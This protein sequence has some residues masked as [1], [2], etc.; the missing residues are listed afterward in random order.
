MITRD[1]GYYRRVAL[2]QTFRRVV[3]NRFKRAPVMFLRP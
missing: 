2:I 1:I 3:Q